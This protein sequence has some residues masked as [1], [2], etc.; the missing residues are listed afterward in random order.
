MTDTVLVAIIGAGGV[1][2]TAALTYLS[3]KLSM[4][5]NIRTENDKLA[6]SLRS[7]LRSDKSE[8]QARFD[9]IEQK[10]QDTIDRAI[11]AEAERDRLKE[12]F[13]LLQQDMEELKHEYKHA[14]EDK[15]KWEAAYMEVFHQHEELRMRYYEATEENKV[16]QTK[17]EELLLKVATLQSEVDSLKAMPHFGGAERRQSDD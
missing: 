8:L 16:T 1:M 4:N 11:R 3:T 5:S 9:K 6:T 17:R 2:G 7:E 10:L 14:V 12:N 13:M 15:E